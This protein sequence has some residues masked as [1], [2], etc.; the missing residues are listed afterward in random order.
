MPIR[1]ILTDIEGTTS[2]ISFVKE[3]LF[4]YSAQN[5][6][7][8]VRLHITDEF[9]QQQLQATLDILW[10]EGIN[11]LSINNTEALIQALLNWNNADRKATP[12][13]ALQGKIWEAGYHQEDYQ[14]HVYADAIAQLRSWHE[15]GIPLY[16][17]SSGSVEGQKLFFEYSIYGNLLPLFSGHFDTHVGAKADITSYQTIMAELNQQQT[18][19]FSQ[20]LKRNWMLPVRQACKPAGWCERGTCQKIRLIR[21]CAVLRKSGFRKCPESAET[22]LEIP[23]VKTQMVFHKGRNKI[24]AVIIP[25][26]A[27]DR[28]RV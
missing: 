26:L 10:E 17:Y 4:P 14:A 23:G 5:L 9:V 18:Y 15:A 13:K 24:I 20:M 25:I 11:H 28:H 8:Y 21:S 16:V 22:L 2:S 27:T 12:L 7:A 6:A 1:I 3:V 19:C